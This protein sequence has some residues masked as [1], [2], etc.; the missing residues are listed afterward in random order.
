[1]QSTNNIALTGL[2]IATGIS[3]SLIIALAMMDRFIDHSEA[4]NASTL[5]EKWQIECWGEDKELENRIKQ[6]RIELYNI[7]RF[8]SLSRS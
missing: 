6:T 4:W 3:G 2:Y 7:E 5:E 8:M 1:M